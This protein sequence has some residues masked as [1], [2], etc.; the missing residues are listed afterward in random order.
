MIFFPVTLLKLKRHHTLQFEKNN[1][2]AT[3][4]PLIKRKFGNGTLRYEYFVDVNFFFL[5]LGSVL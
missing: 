5:Y 3:I 4:D 1:L 2:F